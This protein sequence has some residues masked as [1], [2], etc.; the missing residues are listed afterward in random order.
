MYTPPIFCKL[1]RLDRVGL[2]CDIF[3]GFLI[4]G[5]IGF[6]PA[7]VS[8]VAYR[9][10][11]TLSPDITPELNKDTRLVDK[12]CSINGKH[13]AYHRSIYKT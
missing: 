4:L 8:I 5:E 13:V 3:R 6:I 10:R 2:H 12:E 1:S 7:N 11:Y 9:Y